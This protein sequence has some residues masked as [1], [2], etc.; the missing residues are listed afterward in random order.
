MFICARLSKYRSGKSHFGNNR[1]DMISAGVDHSLALT[2]NNLVF[3]WGLITGIS[4][5]R[6]NSRWL[7]KLDTSPEHHANWSPETSSA[8]TIDSSQVAWRNQGQILH[9]ELIELPQRGNQTAII[10]LYLSTWSLV[11]TSL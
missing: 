5:N 8:T 6:Y 9:A 7:V 4:G 1:V 10:Q 3:Q 11:V 2:S